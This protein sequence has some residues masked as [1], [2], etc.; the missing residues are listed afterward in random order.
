MDKCQQKPKIV[1]CSVDSHSSSSTLSHKY[2]GQVQEENYLIKAHS[3]ITKRIKS[4]NLLRLVFTEFFLKTD[5]PFP[6]G[7]IFKIKAWIFKTLVL[8]A[9]W[10]I[11]FSLRKQEKQ[12]RAQLVL[13]LESVDIAW[14]F[15]SQISFYKTRF[16]LIYIPY[17]SLPFCLP[18]VF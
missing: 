11:I 17:A 18:Q 3:N 16:C 15:L 12:Q 5:F 1:A 2:K 4:N 14:R 10:Y 13:S 6:L 9:S 8:S 7:D